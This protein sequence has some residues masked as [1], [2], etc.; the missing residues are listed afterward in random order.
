MR[1]PSARPNSSTFLTPKLSS[2]A[3]GKLKDIHGLIFLWVTAPPAACTARGD[4]GSSGS[5]QRWRNPPVLQR[6]F[7]HQNTCGTSS[8][9]PGPTEP[10]GTFSSPTRRCWRSCSQA[11]IWAPITWRTPQSHDALRP[12][13]PIGPHSHMVVET[14]V[15]PHQTLGLFADLMLLVRRW[16]SC[17]RAKLRWTSCFLFLS[18]CSAGE[19]HDS[20]RGYIF[21]DQ[22]SL[23]LKCQNVCSVDTSAGQRGSNRLPVK[24]H[25][26]MHSDS[27]S[28]P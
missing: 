17:L 9:G 23:W 15:G 18:Y 11:S 5:P 14:Q 13:V 28:I 25:P 27:T 7:H 19:D 26:I 6:L 24:D 3:A 2:A 16:I 20:F 10:P 12:P 1:A 8:S 21:G 4:G 22:S